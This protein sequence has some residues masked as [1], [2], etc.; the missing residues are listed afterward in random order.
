MD[1]DDPGLAAPGHT[2]DFDIWLDLDAQRLRFEDNGGSGT[3]RRVW[4]R[5]S[6]ALRAILAPP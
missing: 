5:L 2:G 4:V 6:R 3:G 1:E